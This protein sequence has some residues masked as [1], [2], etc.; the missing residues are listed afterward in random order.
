MYFRVFNDKTIVLNSGKAA[1]E[2]LESRSAMYSDR[3]TLWMAGEL[4]RRKWTVFWISFSDPRFKAYRR[5]L[6][7]GLN[8]RAS[9]TYRPIQYQETQV[10][11]KGLANS[12]EDFTAHVRRYVHDHGTNRREVKLHTFY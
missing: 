12:P 11:L 1:L 8:S 5:L 7:Y 6:Q 4:A 3:P 10:L 2:L 9:K